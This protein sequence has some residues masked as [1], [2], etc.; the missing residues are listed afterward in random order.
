[1]RVFVFKVILASSFVA[2]VLLGADGDLEGIKREVE[3][4]GVSIESVDDDGSTALAAAAHRGHASVVAYL[5]KAGANPDA[6]EKRFGW[7]PLIAAAYGGHAHAVEALLEWSA[8]T[9][10]IDSYTGWTALDYARDKLSAA[11]VARGRPSAYT[12]VS[13]DDGDRG[14]VVHEHRVN[15]CLSCDPSR[16]LAACRSVVHQLEFAGA[17]TAA[18]VGAVAARKVQGLA[19]AHVAAAAAL[20]PPQ[21]A[22]V[23]PPDV[24]AVPQPPSSAP[25]P[26]TSALPPLSTASTRGS[27]H[28]SLLHPSTPAVGALA[29]PALDTAGLVAPISAPSAVRDPTSLVLPEATLQSPASLVPASAAA[30]P[31][32]V[33]SSQVQP[34]A[35]PW[36]V[37]PVV[38]IVVLIIAWLFNWAA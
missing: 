15:L 23:P 34:K 22:A 17:L 10:H 25:L 8:D 1:M 9:S 37:I 2:F 33:Q 38:Y 30:P 19:V 14:Y 31:P 11:R 26:P 24:A 16:L 18:E 4:G 20:P 35:G 13:L 7:S 6:T 21:T 5:L 3:A 32:S 12:E 36:A 29:S 28:T 27:S